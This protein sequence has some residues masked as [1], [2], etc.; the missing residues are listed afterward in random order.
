MG[1]AAET[2]EERQRIAGTKRL[3][4]TD[5]V[6]NLREG[7]QRISE[8]LPARF[9]VM[10]HTHAPA[11]EPMNNGST[12]VNLGHWGVDVLDAPDRPAPRTHLVIRHVNGKPE[13]KFC[14]WDPMA[15]PLPVNLTQ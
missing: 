1:V 2:D 7:A 9:I 8:F 4:V 12:Y 11:V 15:G 10:G 3:R 14:A 6:V 13:A 5:A